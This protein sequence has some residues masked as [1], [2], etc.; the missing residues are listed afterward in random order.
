VY[1]VWR[2]GSTLELEEYKKW[3]ATELSEIFQLEGGIKFLDALPV[4]AVGH[5][6]PCP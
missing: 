4:S 1:L 3:A 6:S 5:A 2:P